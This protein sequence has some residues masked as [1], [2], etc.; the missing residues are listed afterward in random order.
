MSSAPRGSDRGTLTPVT[1]QQKGTGRGQTC[2]LPDSGTFSGPEVHSHGKQL[3]SCDHWASPTPHPEP[4]TEP[5]RSAPNP[6]P[7]E[8]GQ[9]RATADRGPAGGGTGTAAPDASPPPPAAPPR[10]RP[11]SPRPRPG[12]RCAHAHGHGAPD[13]ARPVA[14]YVP[15]LRRGARGSL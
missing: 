2:P 9:R 1:A 15:D 3:P 4:A 8:G 14:P 5:R 6:H 13:P 7:P 11:H 12:T 10:D